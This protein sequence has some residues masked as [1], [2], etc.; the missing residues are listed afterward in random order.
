[1]PYTSEANPIEKAWAVAKNYVASHNTARFTATTLRGLLLNGM[2]GD[3]AGHAGV[4][5]PLCAAFFA[6]SVKYVD[7]WVRTHPRL[8]ALFAGAKRG[9]A[10]LS[11][12]NLTAAL[13]AKYSGVVRAHGAYGMDGHNSLCDEDNAEHV[14]G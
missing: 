3:G 12:T 10:E 2:Y 9:S 8:R 1:M 14:V 11:V 13:R 7:E 4:T 6:H 5:P